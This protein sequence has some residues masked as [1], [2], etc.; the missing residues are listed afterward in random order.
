MDKSSF[1]L[2][3]QEAVGRALQQAGLSANLSEP[4]VE[5]HGKPSPQQRIT[6]DEALDFLWLSAD[7][8]YRI[9]DV[10]A[11]VGEENPVVLFV[12]P[13]GFEPARMRRL[14]SQQVSGRSRCWEP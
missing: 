11:F 2:L 14:G 1:A 12:R 10:A 4:V 3:F 8:F 13:S 6:V 7:R 5:F 9:V